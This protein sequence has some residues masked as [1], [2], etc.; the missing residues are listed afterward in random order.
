MW[1]SLTGGTSQVSQIIQPGWWDN[2]DIAPEDFR[3]ESKQVK[4]KMKILNQKTG[5]VKCGEI[6]MVVFTVNI[7]QEAIRREHEKKNSN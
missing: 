7:W 6:S 2:T 3:N 5:G 4:W 1:I